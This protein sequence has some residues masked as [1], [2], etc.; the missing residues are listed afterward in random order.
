[1]SKLTVVYLKTTGHVLAAL[2]RAAPPEG[3]EP[4][5][6]LVGTS[7]TVRA[8]DRRWPMLPFPL[9]LLAAVT[10]DDNQPMS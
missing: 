10:V 9:E 5:T 1:M 2:T 6:A 3:D 4:V 8:S 7:L